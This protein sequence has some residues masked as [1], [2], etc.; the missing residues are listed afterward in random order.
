MREA[1]PSDYNIDLR[2]EELVLEGFS[3]QD[4]PRIASAVQAELERLLRSGN[5]PPGIRN[6]TIAQMDGG[7]VQVSPGATPEMTGRQVARNLYRGLAQ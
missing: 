4:G 6:G 5:I 3:G 1:S 7:R 2:I